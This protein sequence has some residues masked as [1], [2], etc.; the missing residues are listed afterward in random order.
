MRLRVHWPS[1]ASHLF[2]IAFGTVMVYPLLWLLSSSLKPDNEIFTTVGLWPSRF[3]WENYVKGWYAMP[4]LPFSIFARNSLFVASMTVIG[5]VMAAT[6]VGY[7]FA[8]RRFRLRKPLF[9]LMLG[10]MML[11]EQALLVPRYILFRHLDWIDTFR[12]LVIPPFFGGA[13]FIFLMILFMRGIPRELDDAAA[14]DGCSAFQTFWRVIL[15]LSKPP[16]VVTGIFAFLWT[17]NDFLEPLVYLSDPRKFTIPLGLRLF[18]DNSGVVT[19]GGMFAMSLLSIL[20]TMAVFF[21]AQRYFIEGIA[22]TGL[23]G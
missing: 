8:R 23:K 16:V 12:P 17:W 4:S 10:T 1:L 21:V 2:L 9:A 22:T 3:A 7:G 6:V 14:I 18:L 20:P 5:Q 19:W 13:F 11:P 15:P